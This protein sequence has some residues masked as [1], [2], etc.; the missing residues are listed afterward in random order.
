[1]RPQRSIPMLLLA[2]CGAT[3]PTTRPATAPAGYKLV[4]SDEFDTPGKPDPAKWG[5]ELG[6]VRNHEPQRYTDDL[7]NARVE[8]GHLVVEAREDPDHP[9][10]F[11]SASVVTQGRADWQYGRIEVRAKLPNAPGAWPAIWMLGAT[12]GK[13]KWPNC[14]EIDIMELWGGNDPKLVKSTVHFARDGKHAATGGSLSVEDPADAFHVYAVDW[15]PESFNFYVDDQLVKTVDIAKLKVDGQA[16]HAPQY[17]LLNVA[18]DV[19][20][21][22]IDPKN[23][24]MRMLVDWVRVYQKS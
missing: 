1:M 4:W 17:L 20:R 8:D 9:G 21:R 14:G 10:K 22:P 3:G 15:T 2:L 12:H 19:K 13:E 11:T 6:F 24:P 7:A 23:L 18:L 16:F 5:Y